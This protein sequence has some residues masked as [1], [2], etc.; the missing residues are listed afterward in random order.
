MKTPYLVLLAFAAIYLIWGSTYFA[1]LVGL[2]S[3]PPFMISAI[4]FSIA[5]LLLLAYC[6]LKGE[7]FTRKDFGK[8]ALA[9]ILMLF[10][11]TGSVVW[12]EQ[13]IASGVAAIVVASLPFWFVVLDKRQWAFYFNN[14]L[15]ILGLLTGF[16]GILLLFGGGHS[17][18]TSASQ[19]MQSAAMLVLIGGGISWTVGSL[20]AKYSPTKLSNPLNVALQSL[21]AAMFSFLIAGIS[22]E[23]AT[24]APESVLLES[25]LAVAYL[26]VMGSIVAY[27]SY[28]WL[29]AVRNPAQVGTY[30]YVNPVVAVLLG[31]LFAHEQ[32]SMTQYLALLV[33]LSG[34]LLVNLPKYRA[35]KL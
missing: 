5:G 3:M 6:L 4:R 7:R 11:G 25:W 24:F 18:T 9:G 19:A 26:I 13:Y 12:A 2:R 16:A 20:Y 27:S 10:G 31:G 30:A 14:S 29:L 33:V 34:V 28:T 23:W 1:I 15:I 17:A 35:V 22:G 21:G 32:I 8:N